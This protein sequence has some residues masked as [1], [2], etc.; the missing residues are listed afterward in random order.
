[1]KNEKIGSLKFYELFTEMA[2]KRGKLHII[3]LN[4]FCKHEKD[5][6]N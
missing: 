3:D 1:M 5:G 4:E 2:R 6:T